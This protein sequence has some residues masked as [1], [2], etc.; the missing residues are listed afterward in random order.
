VL[1]LLAD[2]LSKFIALALPEERLQD[3]AY[4]DR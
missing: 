1:V 3:L 4:V 2:L